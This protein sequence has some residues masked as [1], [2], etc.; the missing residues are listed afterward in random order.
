M[1]NLVNKE[2]DFWIR[3]WDVEKFD[4]LSNRDERFFALV[5]KGALSWLNSNL[6]MYGKPIKHFILNTGSSYLYLEHDG[7]EYTW[8][9]TS[10]ENMMYMETPRC[11]V[12]LGT[13][14]IPTEE[15][16]MPYTNGVYERVSNLS[17]YKGQIKAYNA[18][19]RRLPIEMEM[20]LNY[21]FSNF[22]ESII[23]VQELFEKIV[24][25]R[26]FTIVYLGQ[27][28]QCSIEIDG[29]TQIQVNELDLASNE[30]NR[31][32]MEFNIKVCTN[33]PIIYK[34]SEFAADVL[35]RNT[36]TNNITNNS[37]INTGNNSSNNNSNNGNINI[38]NNNNGNSNNGSQNN[39]ITNNYPSIGG[40]TS[41]NQV[42]TNNPNQ[43]TPNTDNVINP[44]NSNQNGIGNSGSN[45]QNTSTTIPPNSENN[46]TTDIFTP[47]AKND[48]DSISVISLWQANEILGEYKTQYGKEEE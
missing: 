1:Q 13:F 20:Q 6:K 34:V 48:V 32:T 18:Q 17:K 16:T 11:L 40:N 42:N 39:N 43:N 26:Y 5:T 3:P 36:F 31:R 12:K 38:G 33:L 35:I 24:F 23:F 14:S 21:V 41:T 28:I 19:M 44:D 45:N 27:T 2:E 22:N 10:G 37:D 8:C 7:Y 30:P 15:L 47:K 46:T 4:S 9:E 29:N 25:Q